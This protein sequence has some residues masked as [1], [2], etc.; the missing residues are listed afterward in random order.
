[1]FSL[2]KRALRR[3]G[4]LEIV[5]TRPTEVIEPLQYP[6]S[7]PPQPGERLEV[8]PGVYWLHFPLPFALDHINL[9][10]LADGDGWTL[11]DTGLAG[12]HTRDIWHSAFTRALE[13][14]PI[15]RIIVTHY[16]PD[17]IGQAAW[18]VE[19]HQAPL[20]MTAGEWALTE[21]L[22][23][24]SDDETGADFR[25]FFGLHG[26][27]DEALDNLVG[28]GNT[29]R[30]LVPHLP[31]T[32]TFIAGGDAITINGD[33]WRVHIG[34]GHAPEHAC[35]YR[36]RDQ[37]LVSGDQVLPRI[38]SNL[39]VRSSQP[40]EDPVSDFTGSLRALKAALPASTLVL[41]AHGKPFY[42][43]H[44]RVDA[45]CDH[46]AEQLDAARN[47]CAEQPCTARDI[48]PVLFH[49]KLDGSQMMFA[50][51]ESVAHLNCLYA[52]GRVHR[53][54]RNGRHYFTAA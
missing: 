52:T 5:M 49:R 32:P 15:K 3:P 10:L 16:H 6:H 11:I 33:V 35:L 36:E 54:T 14:K 40:D 25:Q 48:L 19:Q 46:H 13:G 1:M 28:R 22:H 23:A 38:S 37:V 47:A 26:L 7:E 51:S 29:Y 18:L 50:M 53:T 21:Q 34:R 30:K 43:L 39:S 45:L 12:S 27:A 8:A 42:G 4:K 17:H 9:W 31:P 24:S 44:A 20:Y 41:P 2:P